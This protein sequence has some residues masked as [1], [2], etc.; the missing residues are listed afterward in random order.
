MVKDKYI[1]NK[2]KLD[3]SSVYLKKLFRQLFPTSLKS[4]L[5]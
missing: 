1:L 2:S 5:K 4:L 3:L